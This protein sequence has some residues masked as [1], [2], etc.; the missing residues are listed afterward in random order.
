[1]LESDTDDIS[2]GGEEE[3]EEEATP[4]LFTLCL[5]VKRMTWMMKTI[6]KSNHLSNISLFISNSKNCLD[7]GICLLLI[8]L[9]LL[10]K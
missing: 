4:Q 8:L 5:T 1:V 2:G 10:T 3:T 7:V 6:Q 9:L